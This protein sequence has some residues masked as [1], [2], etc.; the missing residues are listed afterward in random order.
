MTFWSLFSPLFLG[1]PTV[2]DAVRGPFWYHFLI[3]KSDQ[4]FGKKVTE[5]GTKKVTKMAT[6]L[7]AKMVPNPTPRWRLRGRATVRAEGAGKKYKKI[8]LG[9]VGACFL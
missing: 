2:G 7:V 9:P 3:Q 6:K 5:N 1:P 4:I 8:Q